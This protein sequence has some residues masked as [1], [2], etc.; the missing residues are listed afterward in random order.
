MFPLP[1]PIRCPDCNAQYWPGEP[2][3]CDVDSKFIHQQEKQRLAAVAEFKD[4]L[5][6]PDDKMTETLGRWAENATD[7]PCPD[8][9]HENATVS[10]PALRAFVDWQREHED[11]G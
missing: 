7:P 1:Y 6:G 8:V 3:E 4:E 9:E 10:L 2:H 11:E 5:Y